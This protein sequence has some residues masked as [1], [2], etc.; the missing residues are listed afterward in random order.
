MQ[1]NPISILTLFC[2]LLSASFARGQKNNWN[3]IDSIKKSTTNEYESKYRKL[4][5]TRQ[6][7]LSQNTIDDTKRIVSIGANLNSDGWSIGGNIVKRRKQQNGVGIYITFSEVIHEKETK[8]KGTAQGKLP[9]LPPP[10]PYVY[11]KINKLYQINSSIGKEMVI[12]PSL[13][14]GSTSVGIRTQFGVSIAMLKPY[15]LK[16]VYEN[17]INGV[18]TSHLEVR[19]YSSIDSAKFMNNSSIYGSAGWKYGLDDIKIVPGVFA[20][21]SL[22]I[23]PKSQK[24]FFHVIS[25][26]SRLGCFSEPMQLMQGQKALAYQL[27]LYAGIHIGYSQHGMETLPFLQKS[28]PF[29]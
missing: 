29:N 16:L 20:D 1:T 2:S 12:L 3:S 9:P 6:V 11:G 14:N 27:N 18:D 19:K 10:K 25:L 28:L 4:K 21:I 26:G 15:C 5:S 23:M 8:Q 24:Y 13:I 22:F 7:V 17:Q